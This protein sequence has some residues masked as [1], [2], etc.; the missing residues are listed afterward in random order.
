MND[1]KNTDF[2][3]KW[4]EVSRN[5]LKKCGKLLPKTGDLV[6]ALAVVF[7]VISLNRMLYPCYKELTNRDLTLEIVTTGEKNEDSLWNNVRVSSLKVNDKNVDLSGF[8][9]GG[10]WEY[11]KEHQLL[12]NYHAQM[13][14][15]ARLELQGVRSMDLEFVRECGS[16]IA[17][18]YLDGTLWQEVDLYEDASWANITLHYETSPLIHLEQ[19]WYVPA[20][21]VMALLAAM[22]LGRFLPVERKRRVETAC[23]AVVFTA[24]LAAVLQMGLIVMQYQTRDAILE[25]LSRDYFLLQKTHLILFF[26]MLI[27][28]ACF[29]NHWIAFGIVAFT[30]EVLLLVSNVKLSIRGNPL[31]PWDLLIADT[32]LSVAGSYQIRISWQEIAVIACTATVCAGLYWM[33]SRCRRLKGKTRLGVLAFSMVMLVFYFQTTIFPGVWSINHEYRV[34]QTATY[35]E[36]NGFVSSFCE[37]LRL[38]AGREVPEDYSRS[39]MQELEEQ[40]TEQ[41]AGSEQPTLR[42]EDSPNIIVIMS[43]SFFDITELENITFESDPLENFHS[44]QQ[45]GISG[46]LLS[47]VFGGNTVTSEF[48]FLT[49]F[50]GTF[51]PENYMV[52]G[53]DVDQ[54]FFSAAG[55]LAKQGYHTVAMHP[56]LA[57]NYNRN[58]AYANMGFE[59]MVFEDDFAPD[60][61]RIRGYVSD[62]QMFEE[63]CGIYER[64]QSSSEEPLFLFGITM[65]N[66]GGYW[67]SHL[68][69]PTMVPFRTEHYLDSTVRSMQDYFAGLR[70]SDEA[71]AELIRFFSEV[72]EETVIVYFGDHMTDAGIGSESMFGLQSWYQDGPFHVNER[73]HTVPYFVW[74]NREQKQMVFSMMDISH[75]LPMVLRELGMEMPLFWEYMTQVRTELP[76]FNFAYAFDQTGA[77]RPLSEMTPEQQ[78]HYRNLE[79]L[80]YDYIWGSRYAERL[81]E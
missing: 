68:Y 63:V 20:I 48:E 47:H 70:S 79:L 45:Q 31:L 18:V 77:R 76:A 50:N 75:L 65:Q 53:N 5:I 21:F 57:E 38:V 56:Y 7:L 59:E 80:T 10:S 40:L 23:G 19:T 24:V 11:S 16:G 12:H 27:L 78:M 39:S 67:S 37:Y 64:V 13:G 14:D 32:A 41:L 9:R 2:W 28:Y 34:Y 55:I 36:G 29:A 49:G 58:I 35:Y 42:E 66:H 17:L 22:L 71:L 6:V 60:A 54:G 62:S 52:Y 25:Y 44:M 73:S 33:R 1:M 46:N 74:N 4:K 30:A 61:E 3:G 43:E 72:D 69:E 81:W 15:I 8:D 26:L 51:F